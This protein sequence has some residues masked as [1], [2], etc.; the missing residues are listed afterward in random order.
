MKQT[1]DFLR[2]TLVTT[3]TLGFLAAAARAEEPTATATTAPAPAVAPATGE[4]ARAVFARGI[5]QRE[6]QDVVSS[7]DSDAQQVFF[8]T[9][10]VGMEGRTVRHRWE[11]GGQTMAEVPFN[12]GAARWRA[13]SSK[14]LMPGQTGTW[15]V[16]VVDE[17][18]NVLRSE[19]LGIALATPEPSPATPP[20]APQR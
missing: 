14:R 2:V 10:L 5:A 8:F 18:G 3:L 13:Y 9:E 15:T 1:R 4:V 7:I 11:L 19:T 17:A 16:S 6:P 20:A 12:V